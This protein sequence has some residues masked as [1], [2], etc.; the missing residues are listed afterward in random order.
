MENLTTFKQNLL[1]F[2]L[3]RNKLI[4]DCR[5]RSAEVESNKEIFDDRPKTESIETVILPLASIGEKSGFNDALAVLKKID[6]MTGAKLFFRETAVCIQYDPDRMD[7]NTISTSLRLIGLNFNDEL[8][9]Q[10]MLI[11]G[12]VNI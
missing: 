11:E 4:C 1:T 7:V 8:I 9:F 3:T 6:G 2:G 5:K 12:I 10:D